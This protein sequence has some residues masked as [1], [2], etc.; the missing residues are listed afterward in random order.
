MSLQQS[1]YLTARALGADVETAAADAGLPVAEAHLLEKDVERGEVV[2]PSPAAGPAAQPKG[3]AMAKKTKPG[4]SVTN[5]SDSKNTIRNSVPRI[6]NL[7]KQRKEIN[8]EIQAER[9]KVNATGIPKAALDHAIRVMEM[10]PDVRQNFD[11]G[12]A[13]ARDAIAVPMSRS[14]FDMLDE[15][16]GPEAPAPVND[17]T[18]DAAA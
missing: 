4:D 16:T 17:E 13:I 11:E 10:D 8:A 14:L 12:V 3:A 18:A 1:H 15:R 7:R 2:I 6:V 5:I 9:E